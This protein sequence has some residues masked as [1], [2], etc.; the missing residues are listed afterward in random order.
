MYVG[1]LTTLLGWVVLF[2]SLELLIYS[3]CV[4]ACFQLFVVY[5][6]EPHLSKTFGKSYDE[7]RSHVGR[8]ISAIGRR[9]S[10]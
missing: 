1:V 3:A 6:E 2:T 8:W 10:A 4:G 5:Y 9:S 7:Y